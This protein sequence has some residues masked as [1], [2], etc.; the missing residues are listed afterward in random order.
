MPDV[1][2]STAATKGMPWCSMGMILYK[3][4]NQP[5][6]AESAGISGLPA[7]AL[8]LLPT[9]AATRSLKPLT[10]APAAAQSKTSPER[11]VAG[12]VCLAGR[13]W[14]GAPSFVRECHPYSC[15]SVSGVGVGRSDVS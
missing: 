5:G 12:G 14:G 7:A 11:G 3:G 2:A 8:K 6:N 9:P 13:P 4:A 10:A 1:A 15:P